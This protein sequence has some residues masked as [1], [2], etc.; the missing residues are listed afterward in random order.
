MV[1]DNQSVT[2]NIQAP[3]FTDKDI[4]KASVQN[5]VVKSTPEVEIV[6]NNI[7]D[8]KVVAANIVSLLDKTSLFNTNYNSLA[9]DLVYQGNTLNG[10]QVIDEGLNLKKDGT[11]DNIPKV[12]SIKDNIVTT[13]QI[14]NEI[15][16]VSKMKDTLTDLNNI[17]NDIRTC[18]VISDQIVMTSSLHTEIA[19]VIQHDEEIIN[20]YN[21]L[22]QLLTIFDYLPQ[23]LR[24][25]EY[26]SK[27]LKLQNELQ[28]TDKEYFENLK[29]IVNNLDN[30]FKVANSVDSLDKLIQSLEEAP[31]IVQDIIIKLESLTN[32]YSTKLNDLYDHL[33]SDLKTTINKANIEIKEDISKIHD[34]TIDMKELLLTN[35]EKIIELS[36]FQKEQELNLKE[37]TTRADVYLNDSNQKI[38][39]MVEE[40][41]QKFKLLE[42]ELIKVKSEYE[43]FK[44]NVDM[45]VKS[46]IVDTLSITLEPIFKQNN[47]VIDGLDKLLSVDLA[48]PDGTYPNTINK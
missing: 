25:S 10:L 13:S 21:N 3:S 1:I 45:Y 41:K 31:T 24:N 11:L 2:Q 12:A 23:L 37:L 39:N 44:N 32:N 6:A 17:I 18:S 22:K 34:Y 19:T 36:Q 46:K 29:T 40:H 7:S 47:M 8:I 16:L 42:S 43:D 28:F 15:T 33:Q 38:N 14:A 9:N 35:K 26:I 30:V 20:L 48:N 5:V 27:Y 4:H